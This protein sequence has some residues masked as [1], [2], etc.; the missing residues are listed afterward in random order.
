MTDPTPIINGCPVPGSVPAITDAFSIDNYS[1]DWPGMP[2]G[3]PAMDI[4]LPTHG[5]LVLKLADGTVLAI[6]ASE[7][8]TVKVFPPHAQP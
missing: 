4:E 5:A 8:T 3:D 1:D 6:S 7:W 2:S